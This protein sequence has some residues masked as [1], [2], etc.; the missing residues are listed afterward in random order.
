M[1]ITDIMNPFGAEPAAAKTLPPQQYVVAEI[2]NAVGGACRRMFVLGP[3]G[4]RR[5]AA[6]REAFT[7]LQ[8]KPVVIDLGPVRLRRDLDAACRRAALGEVFFDAMIKLERQATR[9]GL[10]VVFHNFDGC[11]GSPGEDS[12]IDLVWM[13]AKNRCRGCKVIFTARNPAFVERCFKQF[14]NCRGVV[15]EIIFPVSGQGNA[16]SG[17]GRLR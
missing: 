16:T 2:Q 11:F 1:T 8:I 14:Q 6:V 3:P 7:P 13:E 17:Q 4:S 15:R 12:V 9:R 5:L 10:A